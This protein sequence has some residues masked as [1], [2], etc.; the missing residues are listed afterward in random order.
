MEEVKLAILLIVMITC[1]M[2]ATR[3][4]T[5]R[6]KNS[7]TRRAKSSSSPRS[8]SSTSGHRAIKT[9]RNRWDRLDLARAIGR[10][11]VDPDGTISLWPAP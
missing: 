8:N 7:P 10:D 3:P 1:V 4:V 6:R 9:S 11:E 2:A 5:S